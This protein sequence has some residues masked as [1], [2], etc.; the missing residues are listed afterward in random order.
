M[1]SEYQLNKLV[2]LIADGKTDLFY[3]WA[4]WLHIRDTVFKLDNYECQYCKAR[5]KYSRAEIVHH[6]KHL[7]DRPELA[8]SV[9]DG[10]ERQLV[11]CCKLCHE[12]QHPERFN[13]I[14]K[15]AKKFTTE[16]RWD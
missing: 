6:V 4:S 16:E 7:K 12:E 10:Q 1:I 3:S 14:K 8:L 13:S 5:G 11:S 15:S 2:K 9:C